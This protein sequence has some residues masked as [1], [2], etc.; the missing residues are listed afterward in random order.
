MIALDFVAQRYLSQY[1][2]LPSDIG[3]TYT[4]GADISTE[5]W[6]EVEILLTLSADSAP[7]AT[8]FCL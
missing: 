7:Q 5:S 2:E 6:T 1:T 4:R 3:W 8:C